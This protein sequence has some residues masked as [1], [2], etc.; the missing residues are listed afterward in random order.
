M[1]LPFSRFVNDLLI[2]IN[3][4]PGQLIPIGAGTRPNTGTRPNKVKDSRLHMKWFF[5][6]GGIEQEVPRIWT[7]KEEAWG[8]PIPSATNM[9]S[10]G[11]LRDVLPQGENKLPWYNFCDEAMLVMAGLVYDKVFSPFNRGTPLSWDELVNMAS[12]QVPQLVDLDDML[13]DFPSLF[14]CVA[15]TTQIKP[16]ESLVPGA[17]ASFPITSGAALPNAS[18]NPLLKRMASDVPLA[19]QP[20]KKAKKSSGIQKKKKSH[21][22]ARD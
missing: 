9:D 12:S 1:R 11:I 7:L 19:T 5:A 21:P 3:R 22:I 13:M 6:R 8:L 14:T 18:V 16:R 15:I 20:L 10:V 4:A 17:A 2:T